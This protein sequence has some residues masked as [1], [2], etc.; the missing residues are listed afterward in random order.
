MLGTR[1]S[2]VGKK[3]GLRSRCDKK[4]KNTISSV[5]SQNSAIFNKSFQ[6]FCDKYVA[7]ELFI[8]YI[9][10]EWFDKTVIGTRVQAKKCPVPIML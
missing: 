6:L 3:A 5:I 4:I 7:E 9:K 2:N 10:K 8:N 1:K